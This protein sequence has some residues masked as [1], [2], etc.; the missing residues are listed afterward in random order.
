MHGQRFERALRGTAL[1]VRVEPGKI[2]QLLYTP[3]DG[4]GATLEVLGTRDA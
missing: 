2:T 3:R 1:D 4:V